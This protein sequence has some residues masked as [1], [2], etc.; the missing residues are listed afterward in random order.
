MTEL[1]APVAQNQ[2]I[3]DPSVGEID[4]NR[5]YNLAVSSIFAD[6]DF[7][8]R[9]FIDPLDV[10]DLAKDIAEKGLIQPILVQ[11]WS[12]KEG[13]KWRIV[14]G[15]R[16]FKA[17]RQND[18]PCIRSMIREGIDGMDARVLNLS[19]NLK[20]R[21]LNIKQEAMAIAHFYSAG[22]SEGQVMRRLQMTRGWVQTRYMLLAL[23]QEIQDECAAGMITQ[24][25]IRQLY[26]LKDNVELQFEAVKKMKDA[27]VKG[28]VR[29]VK[30]ENFIRN[31]KKPRTPDEIFAMQEIVREHFGHGLTT[32]LL[33]WAGGAI[34]DLK[35]HQAI[36]DVATKMGKFYEVP[37]NI[38]RAA[39]SDPME[40]LQ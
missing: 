8:C 10:V 20:R 1:N 23:P 9:G 28:K 14:A 33:G 5:A 26:R 13:K 35:A 2:I 6:E 36:R 3:D 18:S 24:S 7:N 39:P 22:W 31:A 16:R 29:E 37:N 19:E 25:Q 30:A 21:D 4:P 38:G 12:L 40:A 15:Y 32:R 27:K 17:T 34:D 11:P